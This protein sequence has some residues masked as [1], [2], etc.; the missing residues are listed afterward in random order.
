MMGKKREEIDM[1]LGQA[2]FGYSWS[3]T[4]AGEDLRTKDEECL[5]TWELQ[6]TLR[7]DSTLTLG[8]K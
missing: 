1:F 6:Y 4:F 2:P 5:R 8:F 7:D 3:L